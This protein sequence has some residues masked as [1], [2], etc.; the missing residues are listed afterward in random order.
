MSSCW[1]SHLTS[2]RGD[3][4]TLTDIRELVT[5]DLLTF[6]RFVRTLLERKSHWTKLAGRQAMLHSGGIASATVLGALQ[7][8]ARDYELRA[9]D[10]TTEALTWLG[11]P[12]LAPEYDALWH[13]LLDPPEIVRRVRATLEAEERSLATDELAQRLGLSTRS[14]QRHLAAAGT[15]LRSVRVEHVVARAERLLEGTAL[16]LDA[17]A[18]MVDVGSAARLVALFRSARGITP[19]AYRASRA[20]G[21]TE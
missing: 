14:L 10:D 15:S 19:G 4:P 5:V 17:I 9:F 16:D 3:D 8:A 6:E 12:E 7:L 11:R 18:A 2:C 1:D 13:E 20:V 21:A